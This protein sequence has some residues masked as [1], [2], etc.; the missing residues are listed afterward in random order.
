M[1]AE[2]PNQYMNKAIRD[3]IKGLPVMT[4]LGEL[5][6]N[7]HPTL[8][9]VG[10]DHLK[11]T[12]LSREALLGPEDNAIEK[13]ALKNDFT[14]FRT[15]YL[16]AMELGEPYSL[17]Y[18][19]KTAPGRIKWV[20]EHGVKES[21]PPGAQGLVP[22][23]IKGII[24]EVE[25]KRLMAFMALK[26]TAHVSFPKD[27]DPLDTIISASPSME[28]VYTFIRKAAKSAS[29]VIITGETGTGKDVVA[30]AIHD[31]S[32][33]KGNYVAV[34]CTAISSELIESE[35]FGYKKGAFSGAAKDSPGYLAAA[36]QGTLFLDEVGDISLPMQTKLLRALESKSYMPVGANKEEHA[37]FRLIT[38]TNKNLASLVRQGKFRSDFFYRIHV[39]HLDLPP[40][41]ER[42][43][44][45]TLLADF[46]LARH[47]GHKQTTLPKKIHQILKT[48]HWPGNIRELQN[49]IERYVAL[50]YLVFSS[51]DFEPPAASPHLPPPGAETREEIPGPKVPAP[52]AGN[53]LPEG[54]QTLEAYMA[55]AEKEFIHQTLISVGHDM[56]KTAKVLGI[57]L[58]TLQRKVKQHNLR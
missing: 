35:F 40:L 49:V 38:A 57:S 18:R 20:F 6:E 30:K 47:T 48:H 50:G 8:T 45:I 39:L 41:R 28:D 29:S 55:R 17:I 11:I 43:G 32:R 46:F 44:D 31:L 37:N 2:N 16:K 51:L 54:N 24:C 19:I 58:R 42:D 36:D 1:G 53:I 3:L 9:D 5:D 23:R 56:H 52:Q 34:N 4:F 13:M 22:R 27:I 12:G 21:E 7:W 14:S 10:Q 26:K 15:S 25:K 33:S